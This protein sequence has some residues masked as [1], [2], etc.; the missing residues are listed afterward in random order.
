VAIDVL[1]LVEEE[2]T[3]AEVDQLDTVG[4]VYKD[5]LWFEVLMA[6]TDFVVDFS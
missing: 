4:H 2:L 1:A 5:V 6:E 3:V